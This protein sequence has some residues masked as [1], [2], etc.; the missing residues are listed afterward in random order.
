ML[1]KIKH[2][3]LSAILSLLVLSL[4][5]CLP[6]STATD[7]ISVTIVIDGD[8]VV[9][10]T[11]EKV[12]YIGI[13]TPEVFPEE[14]FGQEA[15][16]ANR[17]LVLGKSVRLEKDVSETDKYGRLLRYVWVDDIMVNMELVRR[18]LAVAKAYP[19]DTKYRALLEAA[20]L[21]ARLAGRGMWAQV[22]EQKEGA[23]VTPPFE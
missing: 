22:N 21:E 1:E 19:P 18:G 10:S 3:C 13:D 11:G 6:A 4:N 9:I 5:A 23:G 14:P 15:T 7:T 2:I 20:E 17:E 8:T 16:K 12:R